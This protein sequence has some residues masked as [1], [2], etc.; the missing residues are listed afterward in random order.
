[1]HE[2]VSKL[3]DIPELPIKIIKKAMMLGDL[4]IYLNKIISNY[5]NT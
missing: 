5:G 2:K 3:G 4:E 1:M